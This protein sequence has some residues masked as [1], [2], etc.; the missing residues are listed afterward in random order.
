MNAIVINHPS[1]TEIQT[2]PFRAVGRRLMPVTAVVGTGARRALAVLSTLVLG[3]IAVTGLHIVAGLGGAPFESA[4]RG[5]LSAI[6]PGAAAVALTVRAVTI[7]TRRRAW[8]FV[9]AG[10]WSYT[11]AFVVWGVWLEHMPNPPVP[12]ICDALW[13]AFYPCCFAA[14][15]DFVRDGR[16]SR[17]IGV[18]LDGILAGTGVA[19]IGAALVLPPVLA[20]ARGSAA[21]V[22]TDMLY[23]ILDLC[24]AA[25]LLA[26]IGMRG[27]SIDRT[28]TLLAGAVALLTA[29]DVLWELQIADGHLTGNSTPI[30]IYM[31]TFAMVGAAG[32][33]HTR[34]E[35]G[36]RRQHW[37]TL[38][39][40]IG[41]TL[42]ALAMLF[43]D[44]FARI[45]LAALVLS[46]VT[47]LAATMR[48]AVALRDML[49]LSETRRQAMTDDLTSL[50]N[51]RMFT[52]RLRDA[53]ARARLIEGELSAMM[54]DLDNFK[55]LN[56]TLGHD[57]GDEL[58]RLIGKRLRAS[59]RSTDI[60]A[61]LGGDEFAILLDPEPELN[62]VTRVADNVLR[63]LQAPFEVRGLALRVTASVG[64]ASFPRDA[65]SPEELLKC[66]DVAMYQAKAARSGWEL[67]ASERDL[68]TRERLVLASDLA[69]ALERGG[70]EAHFQPIAETRTGR[71]ISA[72]ALVRWRKPDGSLLA[73]A[74][75][76]DAAE[77][78]GL[79]RSL[80]R[81]MLDLALEQVSGWHRGG[82]LLCV[83][84]NATASDLLD[85]AFPAEVA[86]A[87][88]ARGV[89][90]SSLIL[91]ITESSIMS[92][93]IRIGRVLEG[94]REIGVGL[95]LD[96]FGTGY[97]SLTHLRTLAVGFV[98][99]DRSFVARMCEEPADAAI[100]YAT[101]ELA[102][103]LGLQ[104]VAEGVE[105]QATWTALKELG[106]DRIQGYVLGRPVSP[107]EFQ[108]R[109]V[110]VGTDQIGQRE[111]E[112]KLD[113][114]L[115][116]APPQESL[117]LRN[118]VADGVLV[119]SEPRS[120]APAAGVLVEVDA[121]GD[122]DSPGAVIAR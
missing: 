28:W 99:I 101:I 34:P 65:D 100:V 120:R 49:T 97:S 40:P 58:L 122:G 30:F 51:R 37:S 59:L 8:S 111:R 108:R 119:H 68:N 20:S 98:K 95:A 72:E 106:C 64:I 44:H 71:I 63:A 31:C 117:G 67:Y 118:P 75:F 10:V 103:K 54:L 38:V 104:V 24:L 50:P 53:I 9:A 114:V 112:V 89:P 62:A 36:P 115:A 43:Y 113:G 16:D 13:L 35:H 116:D 110:A 26:V 105:D 39:L 74:E 102:H 55:E 61:R 46:I 21:A 86:A 22:T 92:D 109:L 1:A 88:E 14:S 4:L 78:A 73:P 41:V 32:W 77:H 76:V 83:S 2:N 66:A 45:P 7:T 17:P 15:V 121:E 11:A 33:Q 85:T 93:P 6:V 70:I 57:A 94:L 91:E 23:P 42:A 5:W 84:V 18:W 60:V 107:A 47:L 90:P 25:L 96:D 12:S 69:S 3:L 56:V 27:W 80:T 52:A 87:L 79:S 48:M 29:A 81:R 82:D 19:A